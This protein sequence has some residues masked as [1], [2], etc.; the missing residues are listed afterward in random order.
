MDKGESNTGDPTNYTCFFSRM[1]ESWRNTWN[2]RTN[3]TTDKEFPF[4]FVQ[5]S[6]AQNDQK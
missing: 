3:G 1:I 4:G 6:I 5:V 2:E